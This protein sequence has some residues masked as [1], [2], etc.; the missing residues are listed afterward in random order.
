[1]PQ[2]GPNVPAQD[3]GRF[4]AIPGLSTNAFS[5]A[6]QFSD[7]PSDGQA[8][9]N[10]LTQKQSDIAAFRTA[11]LRNIAQTAPYMHTGGFATLSAVVEFYNQGGETS[12]PPGTKDP[13][14][15]PLGL[16]ATEKSDLVSFL[17]ALTGDP[18]PDTLRQ[19]TSAP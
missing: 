14:V 9:L 2:T 12:S 11:G 4:T 5:G 16:T 3:Q 17:Q 19:D 10:G 6:S 13:L 1:V 15:V 8:K 18:I 7:S